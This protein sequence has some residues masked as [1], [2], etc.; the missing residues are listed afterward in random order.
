MTNVPPLECF[1]FSFFSSTLYTECEDFPCMQSQ[2]Y[3][4]GTCNGTMCCQLFFCI[5][6]FCLFFVLTYI[7]QQ[8]CVELN[9]SPNAQPLI[10]QRTTGYYAHFLSHKIQNYQAK[11]HKNIHHHNHLLDWPYLNQFSATGRQWNGNNYLAVYFISMWNHT[12]QDICD[13]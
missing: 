11:N 3:F 9:I 8:T 1:C 13:S 10:P 4:K 5:V 7:M 6:F 2:K 12:T